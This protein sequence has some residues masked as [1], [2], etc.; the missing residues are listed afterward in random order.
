MIP[1]GITR[2]CFQSSGA[3]AWEEN[4][5]RT[6]R[7]DPKSRTA[8]RLRQVVRNE[9]RLTLWITPCFR[10]LKARGDIRSLACVVQVLN[11]NPSHFKDRSRLCMNRGMVRRDDDLTF[12]I[13][14]VRARY[15]D[16]AIRFCVAAVKPTRLLQHADDVVVVNPGCPTCP[17]HGW[18]DR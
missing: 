14:H 17:Q 6:A 11:Q 4:W 18:K 16:H 1:L 5:L 3:K 9:G 8:V 12:H 15:I 2:S 7:S 10:D 13:V